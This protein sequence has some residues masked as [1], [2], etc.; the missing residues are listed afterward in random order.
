[1]H[2]HHDVTDLDVH[3]MVENTKNLDVRGMVENTKKFIMNG[4]QVVYEF[5]TSASDGTL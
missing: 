2:T 1:M 3:G 5:F 4:K